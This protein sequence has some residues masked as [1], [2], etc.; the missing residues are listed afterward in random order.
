M[1]EI[2]FKKCY[3]IAVRSL[4]I[5]DNATPILVSK[6]PRN[7]AVMIAEQSRGVLESTHV[8]SAERPVSPPRGA[9]PIDEY[10]YIRFLDEDE[11]RDR[12]NHGDI[13]L[14]EHYYLT[15]ALQG[16]NS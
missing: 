5:C 13:D 6:P 12:L 4:L 3:Y 8:D 16:R 15:E 7:G 11:I 14:I 10:T 1:I 2:L 9:P